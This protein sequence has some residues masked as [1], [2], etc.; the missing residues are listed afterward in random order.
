MI[1]NV[2][3][4]VRGFQTALQECMGGGFEVLV[5]EVEGP[6]GMRGGTSSRELPWSGPTC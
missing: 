6:A 4:F 5:C 1:Q 2:L 3:C